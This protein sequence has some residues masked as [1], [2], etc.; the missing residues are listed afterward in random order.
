[1]SSPFVR[2]AYTLGCILPLSKVEKSE[3]VKPGS[4]RLGVHHLL[5]AGV[6]GDSSSFTTTT[7][8]NRGQGVYPEHQSPWTIRTAAIELQMFF[9]RFWFLE[10]KNTFIPGKGFW[11]VCFWM[12]VC[13]HRR[14][15]KKIYLE[16]RFNIRSVFCQ[17]FLPTSRGVLSSF[18]KIINIRT[19]VKCEEAETQNEPSGE[20]HLAFLKDLLFCSIL[21]MVE[22]LR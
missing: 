8:L 9:W 13:L 14:S 2:W 19:Q 22:L 11:E 21:K 5:Q 1:M 4:W 7:T 20:K 15:G 12:L 18:T 10:E 6:G 16:T 3:G 17:W